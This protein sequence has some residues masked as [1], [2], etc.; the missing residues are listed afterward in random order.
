MDRIF[1]EGFPRSGNTFSKELLALAFPNI[2]IIP[3]THSAKVLSKEHFVLIRKPSD[4]ISSFM[5]VFQEPNKDAAERWWV[6]FYNTA[7]EN[8]DTSRWILFDD[9]I[10][11]TNNIVNTIGNKLNIQP[12]D[13]DYSIVDKNSA[14]TKYP[15]YTFDKAEDLYINI[16]NNI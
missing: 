11:K 10:N 8:T 9:L 13:I 5:K 6:R 7:L 15:I 1:I 3:F 12:I 16:L 4:A 2:Q 14:Q